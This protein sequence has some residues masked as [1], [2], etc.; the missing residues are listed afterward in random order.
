LLRRLLRGDLQLHLRDALLDLLQR[1]SLGAV[2]VALLLVL[3]VAGS[4]SGENG[5]RR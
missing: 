4:E 2:L 3:F 5:K 1:G